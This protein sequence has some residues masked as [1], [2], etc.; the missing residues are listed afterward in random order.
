MRDTICDFFNNE[1]T[2]PDDL[3][4]FYYSGH[5]IYDDATIPIAI[6]VIT[7][8][9]AILCPANIPSSIRL[10]VGSEG[11]VWVPLNFGFCCDIVESKFTFAL[12][13]STA[14]YYSINELL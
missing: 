7:E 10:V 3:L 6:S 4:L 5:G 11:E 12:S 13:P 1:N 8:T 9:F 2:M 14:Y